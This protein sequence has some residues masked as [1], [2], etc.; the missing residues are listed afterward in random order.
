MNNT[1]KWI[2]TALQE[3]VKQ[4][5][6]SQQ[7][8]YK[9]KNQVRIQEESNMKKQ[10]FASKKIKSLVIIGVLCAMSLTCYG[11]MKLTGYTS[12]SYREFTSFPTA[13]QVEKKVDFTPK[14]VEKFS[15]GFVFDSTNVGAISGTDDNFN[16]VTEEYKLISFGYKKGADDIV[17][18]NREVVEDFGDDFS[19]MTP[20]SLGDITG[21]YSSNAYKFFPPDEEPSAEDL[22]LEKEGKLFISYGSA[23]IEEKTIQSL[24]WEEDGIMY[25]MT[26]LGGNID[27]SGLEEMAKEIIAE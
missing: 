19:N 21:Y 2:Q 4:I 14:F 3:T 11:A 9:I 20:I 26:A 24:F 25:E 13:S 27:Q 12:H 22:Q 15:N 10:L 1:D 18:T 23:E 16:N 5:E 7:L 8:Y 6:P 17:V